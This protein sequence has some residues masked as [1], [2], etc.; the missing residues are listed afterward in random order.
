[1]MKQVLSFLKKEMMLTLSLLAALAALIITP[2]SPQL[3]SDIDWHTLGTLLM[4]LC[5]AILNKILFLR[6]LWGS[7]IQI[8]FMGICRGWECRK[9]ILPIKCVQS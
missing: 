1:M 3:L 2:P 4:M 6:I 5:V 8:Y 7:L 9:L